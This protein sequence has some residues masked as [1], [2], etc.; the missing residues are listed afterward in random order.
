VTSKLP[1][2][3]KARIVALSSKVGYHMVNNINDDATHLVMLEAS[4]TPK[5]VQSLSAKVPI[6]NMLFF[7]DMLKLSKKIRMIDQSSKKYRPPLADD[8]SN[9]MGSCACFFNVEAR[10]HIFSEDVYLIEKTNQYSMWLID[11]IQNCGGSVETIIKPGNN[12][13]V[14]DGNSSKFRTKALSV[15]ARAVGISEIAAAV[16]RAV[17]ILKSIDI[18]SQSQSQSQLS[19]IPA[20]ATN[21]IK[22]LEN[23]KG[24]T[25]TTTTTSSSS[26][27]KLLKRSSEPEIAK[28]PSSSTKG[29]MLPP[30]S[31]P[32]R[33]RENDDNN[34]SSSSSGISISGSH[35]KIRTSV[36]ASSPLSSSSPSSSSSAAAAPPPPPPPPPPLSSSS[37]PP[38]PPSSTTINET[39]KLGE[40]RNR[41][42]ASISPPSPPPPANSKSKK[43]K[44]SPRKFESISDEKELVSMKVG[45]MVNEEE[46][47]TPNNNVDSEHSKIA[48]DHDV[49]NEIGNENRN[50]NEDGNHGGDEDDDNEDTS[51]PPRHVNINGVVWVTRTKRKKCKSSIEH[52]IETFSLPP[53]TARQKDLK[54]FKK[55]NIAGKNVSVWMP[56]R[57]KCFVKQKY[58]PGRAI[59]ANF[60]KEVSVERSERAIQMASDLERANEIAAD[61]ASKFNMNPTGASAGGGRRKNKSRPRRR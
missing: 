49:K 33:K 27:S 59:A 22:I 10:N 55:Q 56:G 45:E 40:K 60:L 31:R 25:T 5:A 37:P 34:T 53:L 9:M 21:N 19:V 20:D 2:K 28:A 58:K 26:S 15:G 4:A 57:G 43:R 13:F 48:N 17:P 24:T 47:S 6:V 32:K 12:L 54:E 44:V 16:V 14:V 18:I 61:T 3:E 38:P 35:K 1:K 42:L 29:N 30:S 52:A 41:K 23:V 8:A 50:E 36:T 51:S 46:N 11:T 39:V 7:E